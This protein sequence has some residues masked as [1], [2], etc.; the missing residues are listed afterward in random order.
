MSII[1]K[2][3]TSRPTENEAIRNYEACLRLKKIYDKGLTLQEKK[4]CTIERELIE[5]LGFTVDVLYLYKVVARI[6][7][8]TEF[9]VQ[10]TLKKY[11]CMLTYEEYFLN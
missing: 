2:E 4:I 5:E 11:E 8:K 9:Y 7:N 10:K 3:V 1:F 6:T